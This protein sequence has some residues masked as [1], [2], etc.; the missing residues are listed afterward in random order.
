MSYWNT[1]AKIESQI[2]YYGILQQLSKRY[3]NSIRNAKCRCMLVTQIYE[4]LRE[5]NHNFKA[6]LRNFLGSLLK[7][8]VLNLVLRYSSV[9]DRLPRVCKPLGSTSSTTKSKENFAMWTAIYVKVKFYCCD[10]SPWPKREE[11]IYFILHFQVTIHHWGKSG[12]KFK[13][14][15]WRQELTQRPFEHFSLTYSSCLTKC[16]PLYATDSMYW[17]SRNIPQKFPPQWC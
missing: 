3:F 15:T 4:R 12:Q 7:R 16:W 1:K 6:N 5:K 13:A 14:V 11:G 17:P 2:I 8:K 9:A 10:E